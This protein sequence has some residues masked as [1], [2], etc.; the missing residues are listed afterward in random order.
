[1]LNIQNWFI[2][3]IIATA[4]VATIAYFIV[5][6][7]TI[8]SFTARVVT[9][10]TNSTEE[11]SEWLLPTT[12]PFVNETWV[13]EAFRQETPA[14]SASPT[15]SIR[16]ENNQTWIEEGEGG[17]FL[18]PDVDAV[19][20]SEIEHSNGLVVIPKLPDPKSQFMRK[21]ALSNPN[22]TEFQHDSYSIN[23]STCPITSQIIVNVHNWTFQT[24]DEHGHVKTIGGDEWFI[25]YQDIEISQTTCVAHITDHNDGQYSLQF[26]SSP[27]LNTSIPLK[28]TGT[29]IFWLEYSCSVGSILRPFKDTWRTNG[30]LLTKWIAENIPRPPF[31]QFINPN[32]NNNTI[33]DLGTFDFLLAAGDSVMQHFVSPM[34]NHFYFPNMAFG[35]NIADPLLGRTFSHVMNI[36]IRRLRPHMSEGD[37][38]NN[39]IDVDNNSSSNNC[40]HKPRIGLI[41]GYAAWELQKPFGNGMPIPGQ[42]YSDEDLF[43]DHLNCLGT[44]IRR[45]QRKLHGL[46]I[47]WKTGEYIHLHVVARDKGMEWVHL[48]RLEYMSRYRTM[49]L[50][51][52]QKDVMRQL[53]IPILDVMDASYLMPDRHRG[54]GDAIHY[55][56]ETNQKMLS[57]F[58]PNSNSHDNGGCGSGGDD[59]VNTTTTVT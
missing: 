51:Q 27:Y 52:K 16:L 15:E 1:M 25:Y 19:V 30:A 55:D 4:L 13:E 22:G 31:Q 26:T 38:N 50:Y 48:P 6:Q 36:I 2:T 49:A 18:P 44:M 47:I 57:W 41:L 3:T 56:V 43:S 14:P 59:A 11:S 39:N 35:R 42:P 37:G 45:L 28:E 53:N 58:F 21:F 32:A 54:P 46:E 29:L 33:I 17:D 23:Y 7:K 20:Y 10:K 9:N 12:I 40:R 8:L 5:D 24:L 34:Y